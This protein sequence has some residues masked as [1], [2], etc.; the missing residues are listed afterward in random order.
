MSGSKRAIEPLLRC[1]ETVP[2][3]FTAAMVDPESGYRLRCER[4][5]WH[6]G[7]HIAEAN[8]P[9]PGDDGAYGDGLFVWD[10]TLGAMRYGE[11]MP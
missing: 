8:N 5:L 10:G 3:P 4:W 9:I 11:R 7:A 2:H 6:K 1:R